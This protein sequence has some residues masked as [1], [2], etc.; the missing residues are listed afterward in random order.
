MISAK[1]C[2]FIFIEQKYSFKKNL[3]YHYGNP[4]LGLCG[5]CIFRTQDQRK[6]DSKW[7]FSSKRFS[8]KFFIYYAYKM[9]TISGSLT[10]YNIY[11]FHMDPS[12]WGD[13][14]TFRP[15]RFIDPSTNTLIRHERFMPFGHGKRICMGESLAKYRI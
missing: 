5:T 1:K 13:P 11:W 4:T 3:G 15:E 12:Y 14:E 7:I 9:M 10:F 2:T 6:R 8:S